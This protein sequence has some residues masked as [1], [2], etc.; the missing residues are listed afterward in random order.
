MHDI[1]NN[2][3]YCIYFGRLS[4]IKPQLAERDIGTLCCHTRRCTECTII[5][6]IR[7]LNGHL[8][9]FCGSLLF[10][11]VVDGDVVCF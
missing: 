2:L 7:D 6:S 11:R 8:R 5:K 1:L 10:C 3:I 4:K 9:V